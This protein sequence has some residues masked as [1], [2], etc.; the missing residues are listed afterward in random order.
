MNIIKLSAIDSTNNYLKELCRVELPEDETFVVAKN[1]LAGRGQMGAG[2]VSKEGQSLTF[3]VF[4]L[5]KSLEVDSQ[6]K[7]SMA[8]ALAL[9]DALS[10]FGVPNVS[11]KW[12]NDIMSDKKK[13]AGILIEN[14][15][16]RSLI[17][18]SVI[19]IGVNVNEIE[20][21]NLPQATSMYLENGNRYNL[22]EVFNS[23]AEKLT[24]NLSRLESE[25]FEELKIQYEKNLFRR[26]SISVFKTKEG[27]L[28]NAIIRGVSDQGELM[29]ETEEGSIKKFQLKEIAYIF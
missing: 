17:K 3:S 6:F 10:E 14:V 11:V 20:F 27:N 24:S 1:Q 5:F 13:L 15:L 21:P 19:G 12:P 8:V 26:N 9:N 25:T 29:V 16:E 28:F 18:Y 2:W 23:I 4:K 22:K 7:I